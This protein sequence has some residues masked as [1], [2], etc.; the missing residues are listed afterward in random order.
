LFSAHFPLGL[1]DLK[2]QDREAPQGGSCRRRSGPGGQD[3][4]ESGEECVGVGSGAEGA[5]Q[6]ALPEPQVLR[7]CG[8]LQPSYSK[9]HV[10]GN[11]G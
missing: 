1:L 9:D 4:R 7:G 11:E 5:G 10:M 6:P 2:L 3:V 8:L